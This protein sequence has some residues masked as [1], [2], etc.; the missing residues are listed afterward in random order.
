[1]LRALLRARTIAAREA[2]QVERTEDLAARGRRE[3]IE[4]AG[5]SLGAELFAALETAEPAASLAPIFQAT[6]G[7]PG[8]W[9]RAEPDE[10]PEQADALAALIVSGLDPA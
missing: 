8:L 10:A 7:G 3:G 1:M 6:L 4:L 5:W 9:L 2:G